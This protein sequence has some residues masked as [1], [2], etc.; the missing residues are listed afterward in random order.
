MPI[1]MYFIEDMNITNP[2]VTTP[3]Q[4]Q[5]NQ[6]DTQARETLQLMH[7]PQYGFSHYHHFDPDSAQRKIYMSEVER[8]KMEARIKRFS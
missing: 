5:D 4:A 7:Q 2:N 1:A 3:E 8:L 6:K